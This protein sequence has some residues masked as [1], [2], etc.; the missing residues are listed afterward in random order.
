MKIVKQKRLRTIL[1]KQTVMFIITLTISGLISCKNEAT[2]PNKSDFE[3]EKTW[4]EDYEPSPFIWGFMNANGNF[5]IPPK[6][7]EL[8]DFSDGLAACNLGGKWGYIDPSG[9]TS[10]AHQF[11]T[12]SDFRGGKALVQDFKNQYFYIDKKGH[13][14]FL[15]PGSECSSFVDGYAFFSKN[16]LWG[17]LSDNGFVRIQPQFMD[18]KSGYEGQ[19]IVKLGQNYGLIDTNLQWILAP[20]FNEIKLANEDKYVVKSEK[21]I[22]I[23]HKNG[24]TW[25]SGIQNCSVFLNAFCIV[26]QHKAF[27]IMNNKGKITYSTPNKLTSLGE[28]RFAE[29]V[30]ST[31]FIVNADGNRLTEMEYSGFLVFSEGLIGVLRGENWTYISLDGKEIFQPALPLAWDCKERRIRYVS[32]NGYGFLNAEGIPGIEASYPEARDFNGG[33]ARVAIFR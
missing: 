18:I 9:A 26:Q 24:K 2:A 5:T 11:L 30:G 13:K 19:F 15:C 7:D 22:E 20:K 27:Q 3:G 8:R 6:Y 17:V 1:L 14:L 29:W 25:L 21:E 28:Q 33:N 32:Q 23:V 10:V 31:A 4:L 12:C 16:D